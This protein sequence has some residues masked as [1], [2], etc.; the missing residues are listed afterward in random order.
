M[1]Q[2]GM[3]S[4]VVN[5][6]TTYSNVPY[7]QSQPYGTQYTHTIHFSA[8]YLNYLYEAGLTLDQVL[9]NFV[10]ELEGK[11]YHTWNQSYSTPNDTTLV[12]TYT[13]SSPQVLIA[14]I[15][16]M[17]VIAIIV[18]LIYDIVT[19]VIPKIPSIPPLTKTQT[20]ILSIAALAIG[21]AAIGG[22]AY[23]L[24]KG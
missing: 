10:S 22:A 20:T 13:A 14:L 2:S 7:N 23:L 24:F 16:L 18:Y 1:S 9:S 5:G 4:M 19:V 21:I 11:G 3:Y 15:V 8:P 6:V 17:A 12:I